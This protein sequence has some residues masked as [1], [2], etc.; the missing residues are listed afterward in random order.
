[1]TT[2][3]SVAAASAI[4]CEPMRAL[5]VVRMSR[6][7]AGIMR[8]IKPK[9]NSVA[10]GGTAQRRDPFQNATRRARE[11]MRESLPARKSKL[12]ATNPTKARPGDRKKEDLHKP[13]V[14]TA[15]RLA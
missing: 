2:M 14:R 13:M 15:P 8:F 12:S 3:R 5:V 10:E 4:G 9:G 11:P 7:G 6:E 1:M